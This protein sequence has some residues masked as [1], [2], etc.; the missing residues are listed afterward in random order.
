MTELPKTATARAETPELGVAGLLRAQALYRR[1]LE[2]GP[3]IVEFP[4]LGYFW[5]VHPGVFN[6]ALVPVTELFTR[7]L[8]YPPGGT[9]LEMGSGAGITSVMAAKKGCTVSAVDVSEAA[10]VN[11]QANVWRHN[12]MHRV[13]VLQSDLFS[14]LPPHKKFDVI[15]WNS[16]FVDG[17]LPSRTPGGPDLAEALVDPDYVTH[18]NFLQ[19]AREYL[20]SDGCL[21]IGFANIG[22]W[23][24]LRE[25]C[26]ESDWRP[27]IRRSQ[28]CPQADPNLEVQLVELCRLSRG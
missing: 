1:H 4:L 9:F 10:V 14:A 3:G 22:N 11:T 12:V 24:M 2:Q 23:P 17:E 21:L 6:P 16:N 27:V 5:E 20:T 7:W 15:Y 13:S 25:L 26:A 19:Q 18:R 28:L 8:L